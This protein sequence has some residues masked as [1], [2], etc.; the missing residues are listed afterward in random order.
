[1]KLFHLTTVCQTVAR[2]IKRDRITGI[3]GRVQILDD[4]KTFYVKPI[5]KK[6][7]IVHESCLHLNA[8]PIAYKIY[9][10]P[11]NDKHPYFTPRYYQLPVPDKKA[12]EISEFWGKLKPGLKVVGKIIDDKFLITHIK[13]EPNKKVTNIKRKEK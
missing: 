10:L 1:M 7:I 3:H 8:E 5:G 6:S 9:S 12:K 4:M 2:K 11:V 13:D